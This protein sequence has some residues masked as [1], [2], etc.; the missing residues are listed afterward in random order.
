MG[1]EDHPFTPR[2]VEEL[3]PPFKKQNIIKIPKVDD[4]QPSEFFA[5]TNLFPANQAKSIPICA[6]SA[7]QK[8]FS[9]RINLL[10]H[11]LGEKEKDKK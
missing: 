3:P 4:T 1:K 6:R 8:L 11:P 7:P 2:F 5:L 10:F 9:Q